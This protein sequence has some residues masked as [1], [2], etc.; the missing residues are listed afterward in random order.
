M[1]IVNWTTLI[2]YMFLAEAGGGG[3]LLEAADG[4]Q[5][6]RSGPTLFQHGESLTSTIYTADYLYPQT[7]AVCCCITKSRR[8]TVVYPPAV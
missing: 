1:D 3:G 4:Q 2:W 6:T 7:E 5:A 8:S